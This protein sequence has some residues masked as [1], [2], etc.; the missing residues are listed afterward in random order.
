MGSSRLPGKVLADLGG[1]PV[2]AFL[3]RRLRRAPVDA[4][5]LA[6]SDSALDDPVAALGADC[7][8]P[9]VRG[10]ELDVLARYVDALDAH[11]ADDVIRITAD[12]PLADP[13]LI[14]RALDVHRRSG[15]DYT[16]NTLVRTYPD[17]LDVEVVRASALR[18]ADAEAE[19]AEEREHVT[20][21]LYRRPERFEL[22]SFTHSDF[23]ADHRWT[24]DT[25]ADLAF[26]R[27]LVETLADPSFAWTQALGY[28]R[29]PPGPGPDWMLRPTPDATP[30]RRTWEL[31]ERGAPAGV[32]VVAVR[33]GV[34]TVEYQ[35]LTARQAILAADLLNERL[36]ADKQIRSLVTRRD[37]S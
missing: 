20:P 11:P 17:G 34:G 33:G 36:S 21:F 6:T 5:V 31:L 27:G 26:L 16:S 12:C 1:E 25:P 8:V 24:L 23:L 28:D 30:A 37:P 2:L 32:V 4:V 10:S 13:A 22:A 15:A 3:L 35:G 29:R 7:G 9:V 14:S 19:A 18:V